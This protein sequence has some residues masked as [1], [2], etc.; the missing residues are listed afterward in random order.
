MGPQRV[1]SLLWLQGGCFA[2]IK[3]P[4]LDSSHCKKG[5]E[6]SLTYSRWYWNKTFPG[7]LTTFQRSCVARMLLRTPIQPVLGP[8]L[9]S[10]QVSTGLSSLRCRVSESQPKTMLRVFS[11]VQGPGKCR[12]TLLALEYHEGRTLRPA[13]LR[14]EQV[15][16]R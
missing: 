7:G 5:D 14:K 16:F 10:K 12:A 9:I 11:R 2:Y 1:G 3:L 8:C 4:W 6:M 13:A 15:K